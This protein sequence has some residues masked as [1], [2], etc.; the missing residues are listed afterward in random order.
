MHAD[1]AGL[2]LDDAFHDREAN[3]GAG[4]RCSGMRAMERLE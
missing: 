1:G 2:A 3:P 4:I